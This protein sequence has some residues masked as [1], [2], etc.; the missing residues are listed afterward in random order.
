MSKTS[1]S[2]K[3]AANFAKNGKPYKQIN[4]KKIISFAK[5]F[6]FKYANINQNNIF[7]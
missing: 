2:F 4:S 7:W 6:N 1:K 5:S 3:L